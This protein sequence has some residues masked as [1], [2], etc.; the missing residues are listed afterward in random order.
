MIVPLLFL[1]VAAGA[2]LQSATG[3]GFSLLSAP[4]L[5]AVIDP[6]PAIGVLAVLGLEVNLMTLLTE[7]RR[8]RPLT[9]EAV[10]LVGCALP[11]ALLGVVVLRNLP[12]VAL[13]LLLSA[14]VLV[15]LLVRRALSTRSATVPVL[16]DGPRPRPAWSAPVAGLLSGALS[17]STSTSGPPLLLHLLGRGARPSVVRDTLTVCF[18]ALG[19][20]TPIALL[21]T[22][23][24]KA[25]PDAGLVAALLPAAFVGH[26]LGRRVFARLAHGHRYERVVTV[27]LLLSV[28]A[29]LI[30]V[31]T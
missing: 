30:T 13:Q 26:L 18:L 1:A 23:S 9:R 16:H 29:G 19:T 11:G 22:R 6:Q 2:A 15:T 27:V 31:V 3:F 17:T 12:A 28:T 4:I 14:G 10:V 21:V 20:I 5:F 8:P 7:G 25:I 24:T